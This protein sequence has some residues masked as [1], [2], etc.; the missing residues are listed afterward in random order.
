MH[1]KKISSDKDRKRD[2]G[3]DK[4]NKKIP[5]RNLQR[6]YKGCFTRIK[7]EKAKMSKWSE[8]FE[9]QFR[10]VAKIKEATR[11]IIRKNKKLSFEEYYNPETLNRLK[12]E[13]LEK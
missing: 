4:K 9:E 2:K 7:K 5:K 12:K 8:E 6:C 1:G 11:E 10:N 3:H 13:I